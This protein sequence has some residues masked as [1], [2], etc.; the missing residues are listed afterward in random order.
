MM[1]GISTL[2]LSILI[3]LNVWR[4][5]DK[6]LKRKD[7]LL[8]NQIKKPSKWG[9]LHALEIYKSHTCFSLGQAIVLHAVNKTGFTKYQVCYR[10]V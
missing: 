6:G 1:H 5:V 9:L 7:L 3:V 2:C 4:Q 8:S 10:K